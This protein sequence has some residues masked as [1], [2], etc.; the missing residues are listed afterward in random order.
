MKALP[1]AAIVLAA[2]ACGKQQSEAT[3]PA[4]PVPIAFSAPRSQ[5][6]VRVEKIQ[7][8]PRTIQKGHTATV[9]LRLVNPDRDR[10]VRVNWFAPSGWS[11]FQSI[12]P[13]SAPQI[14]IAPPPQIFQEPGS[15]RAEVL[16]GHVYQGE[17]SVDVA[18]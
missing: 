2:F 7:I 15:Y 4:Q 8:D 1:V 3:P 9:S 18:G 13:A 11:V 10:T 14:T 17:V 12:A 5:S 6:N 16:V